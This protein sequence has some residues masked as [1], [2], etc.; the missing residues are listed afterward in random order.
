MVE[1]K[2]ASNKVEEEINKW[3]RKQESRLEVYEHSL[4][5]L[6]NK[7]TK[8]E[9]E[10][11][12]RKQ[13]EIEAHEELKQLRILDEKDKQKAYQRKLDE[14]LKQQHLE[15]LKTEQQTAKLLKLEITKFNGTC[16]D[17]LRFWEQFEAEVDKSNKAAITKLSYLHE[18]LTDQPKKE[19]LGLPFSEEGYNC[20]KEILKRKY[21]NASEIVQAHGKEIL[22]L[23]KISTL[24]L[25]QIHKFYH[26]L[27][28]NVNSLK[29]L[30]KLDT[31]EILVC[32]TLEK[33][34]PIK[35]DL[36]RTDSNWQNWGFEDLLQALQ[37]YTLRNPE[38]GNTNDHE[39]EPPRRREPRDKKEK[40][41]RSTERKPSKCVYCASTDH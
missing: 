26:M 1:L 37:D 22:K 14:E 35:S 10:K 40:H 3:A 9:Q 20:A 36:I 18:L 34:E 12:A 39:S 13:Q 8:V 5:E 4:S 29:S 2:I 33:L 41:Y 16:L 15:R 28:V 27:N 17:W 19:I 32:K 7:L 30:G 6:E 38:K 25:K 23:P 31:T 11:A 24:N 21:S